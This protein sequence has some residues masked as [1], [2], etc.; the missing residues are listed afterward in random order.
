VLVLDPVEIVGHKL[1]LLLSQLQLREL[2]TKISR[3]LL[4]W[5]SHPF[6]PAKLLGIERRMGPDYALILILVSSHLGLTRIHSL[7]MLLNKAML[8]MEALVVDHLLLLLARVLLLGLNLRVV[9]GLPHLLVG[10]E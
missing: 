5:H 8:L 10:H 2:L 1:L 3:R 6:L 7:S 4:R 9:D